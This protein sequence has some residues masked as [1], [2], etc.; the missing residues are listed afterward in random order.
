M[1]LQA[2]TTLMYSLTRV[3]RFLRLIT[4]VGRELERSL[5]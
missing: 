3:S 5:T 4:V 1:T 2:N